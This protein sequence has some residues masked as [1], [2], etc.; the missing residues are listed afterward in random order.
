MQAFTPEDLSKDLKDLEF[1]NEILP[2]QHT[3]GVSWNLESDAFLFRISTEEQQ[4]T[5]RG[6]LSTINSIFDPFGF[7]APV[8]ID[9][10][11]LMRQLGEN[12]NMEM[13]FILGKS[14]VAPKHGHTIPRLELCG[15]VLAVEIAES[16]DTH[17]YLH[18]KDFTF[19]T[20]SKVVLGYIQNDTRRFYTY[21][22]NRVERIRASTRPQQWR[23]VSTNHNPADQATRYVAAS[24]M[25]DNPWLEG[26]AFLVDEHVSTQD[27]HELQN[28]DEDKEVR[29]EVVVLKTSMM[30]PPHDQLGPH[31]FSRFSNW[32]KLVETIAH[33]QHIAQSVNGADC[34]GW[35][36]C[37]KWKTVDAFEAAQKH[38]LVEVQQ[39]AYQ[40]E[41][42]CL[43][44]G[45]CLPK[46]SSISKLS[47]FIGRHHI[48]ILIVRHYHEQIKHQGRHIT[49]GSI[50]SAGFWIT[51]AK[52]LVSSV[53]Y[54]CVKCRKLRGN[55][56]SQKM[57]D[58]SSDRLET[59][60]PLTNV[61][62]DCFGPWQIV[63][64][65]TR[66]GQSCNKRWAVMFTCLTIRA[67]HIE[68][69]EEL[70][71]SALINALRRF[72][73]IRGQV[74]LFR[75]DRG[76]NFVGSTDNLGINAIN[77]ED[78]SVK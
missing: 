45:K 76:T 75:S 23:Y 24:K 11:L 63:T 16:I 69:V 28:P 4:F 17:L 1:G 26:P 25:Q 40:N 9:G 47:P 49:E 14:K 57:A 52:S 27:A 71:S 61:G 50:R 31:R 39:E 74:K 56:G 30:D 36:V 46:S 15:A 65:K 35:H 43:Q 8:I 60:P 66:G 6:V 20:D 72:M 2:V 42:Q 62:V 22:A 34:S 55:L 21:V 18:I 48:A 54:K 77:V 19:Y 73:A 13:G 37:S 78:S 53:I 12:G 32:R 68:V 5:R 3:L 7:L 10:K 67:V 33:L 58:L 38:L 59:G 70:S 41:I 51:G 44:A 64:R 29:A